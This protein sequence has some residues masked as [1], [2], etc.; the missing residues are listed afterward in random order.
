VVLTGAALH[1]L[2]PDYFFTTDLV[3]EGNIDSQGVLDGN[4]RL[5]GGGDPTFGSPNFPGVKSWNKLQTEY[6]K[7]IKEAGIT[8]VNGWVI[9]DGNS[10]ESQLA[11]SSWLFE[12]LGNY[13][14]A[15]AS[16]LSF[17]ENMYEL[18]LKPG[19]EV[20]KSAKILS[21]KPDLSYMEFDNQLLTG[22]RNS[23]DNAYIYGSE[24]QTNVVLRGTIP[25]G[26]D[27]FTIRGAI[28]D[29]PF[30]AAYL[31]CQEL[32][33]LGVSV[34]KGPVSAKRSAKA[35][36]SQTLL[37]RAISPNI[38]EIVHAINKR[39]QNLY[40]EHLL[41]AI[42]SGK[43]SV[44]LSKVQNYWKNQ[45]IDLEG[46]AMFDG[47]GNSRKDLLTA[48][49]IVKILESLSK[50]QHFACFYDSLPI[51]G[52]DGK[53]ASLLK[54]FSNASQ[55]R[56]KTGFMS[57]IKSYAGYARNKDGDLL[58]FA[59]MT[60]HCTKNFAKRNQKLEMIL[61]HLLDLE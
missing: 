16:G 30:A 22:P 60:N 57:Q 40:A 21:K 54:E 45:G 13:Y 6:A 14:G 42:G 46:F 3:Y 8:K 10:F 19:N 9:G 12:D 58:A 37:S 33:T 1:L 49:Q 20:G 59:L 18:I 50:S 52:K 44:G 17:H 27:P 4:I 31:L 2:G 53:L 48:S 39:S 36:L 41:K 38:K 47:S 29:P 25:L 35:A 26:V 61:Q 32:E 28:L 24:Y 5:I 51:G 23:G 56:A 7:I 34:Q 15:G 11:P 55:I 43:E